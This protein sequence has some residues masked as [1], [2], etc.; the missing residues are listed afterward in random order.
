ML[1]GYV[2]FV[3][4][5]VQLSMWCCVSPGVRQRMCDGTNEVFQALEK[6][7]VEAW[8]VLQTK[9]KRERYFNHSF[10]YRICYGSLLGAVREGDMP[11]QVALL[12]LDFGLI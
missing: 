3:A 9:K 7:N 5:T 2:M 4:L 12:P 11:Y 8:S 6:A 1:A 10:K